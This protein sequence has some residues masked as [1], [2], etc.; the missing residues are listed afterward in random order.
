VTQ[1]FLK[2]V[3]TERPASIVNVSSF[4]ACVVSPGASSYALTKF[5][6]T[7]LTE[8]VDAENANIQ[9]VSYHPGTIE[10]PMTDNH[11]FFR[12]FSKDTCE[13]YLFVTATKFKAN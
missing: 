4:G 11:E 8:F 6:G 12:H 9:A 5:A 1:A 10:T 13:F 7:R 2:L 3:G